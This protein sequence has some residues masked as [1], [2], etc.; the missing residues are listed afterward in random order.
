[1]GYWIDTGKDFK[2]YMKARGYGD[3]DLKSNLTSHKSVFFGNGMKKIKF[4]PRNLFG[5]KRI[6]RT[7]PTHNSLLKNPWKRV[8]RSEWVCRDALSKVANL[9]TSLT[10]AKTPIF[11]DAQSQKP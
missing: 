7:M 1:M 2:D 6:L 3:L 4:Y 11:Q 9:P 8:L 5:A 10:S